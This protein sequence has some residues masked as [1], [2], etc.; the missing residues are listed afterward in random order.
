MFTLEQP[1]MWGFWTAEFVTPII[2]LIGIIGNSLAVVVMKSKSLRRKSYSHL[3]CALA[4]FDSLTLIGREV[5]LVDQ[6]L[7]TVLKRKGIFTDF[8]NVACKIYHFLDQVCYLMSSWLIVG[9]S[10]ERLEAVCFPLRK[11][12]L[13]TQRGAIGLISGLFVALAVSQVFR[14]MYVENIHG[15]CTAADDSIQLFLYL[16]IYM[17]QFGLVFGLPFILVLICNSL[18]IGQI[19]KVRKAIGDNRSA[20]VDRTHKT[21]YMLLTISFAYVITMLPLIIIAIVAHVVSKRQSMEGYNMYVAL[22]PFTD[23]F[24][25]VSYTNYA[26]N[27]FVYV[28]SGQSFRKELRKI[29]IRDRN[30]SMYGTRTRTK[31]ELIRLS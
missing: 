1:A 12:L 24:S 4:L 19:Y 16:H 17:Y 8:S 11:S 5:Q 25:V 21:T 6:L 13:R 26:M 15:R 14:L 28:L 10:A 22:K 2:T 9:M 7:T 29:M 27:F 20:V 3:L 31:D 18:V 30:S 23:L